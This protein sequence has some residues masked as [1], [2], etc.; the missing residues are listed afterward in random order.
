MKTFLV[1]AA[2]SAVATLAHAGEVVN[3][4]KSGLALQGYDPV[5]YFTDGKADQRIA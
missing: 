3:L 5:G 2:I 4:D 1:I